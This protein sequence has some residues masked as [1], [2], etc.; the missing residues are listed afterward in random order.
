MPD[1]NLLST[2]VLTLLM[3]VGL[4]FFLRASVKDR[5]EQEEFDFALDARQVSVN[6]RRYL[7]ARAWQLEKDGAEL[8]F[9]GVVA[10]SWFLAVFLTLLALLGLVC[11][12]LVLATL[13]PQAGWLFALLPLLSPLAGVFYWKRAKRPEQVI[14]RIADTATGS[15]LVLQAHRDEIIALKN[16]LRVKSG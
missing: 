10:P 11:L 2:F 12:G 15:R 4:F 8:V 6:L 16:T 3:L 7:E 1:L 13:L 5:T 14:A 9:T